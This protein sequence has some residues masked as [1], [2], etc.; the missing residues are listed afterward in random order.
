MMGIGRVVRA[1]RIFDA[2]A[3]CEEGMKFWLKR[4]PIEGVG[5]GAGVM[6]NVDCIYAA[7]SKRQIPSEEKIEFILCMHGMNT[8][9]R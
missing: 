5:E 2:V 1:M 4:I 9:M 3:G 6:A 8:G 7:V